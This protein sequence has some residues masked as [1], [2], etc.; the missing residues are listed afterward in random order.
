VEQNSEL[1]ATTRFLRGGVSLIV[2]ATLVFILLVWLP[3]YRRFF[4][5]SLGIGI[6]VAAVLYF[7]NKHRPVKEED[8]EN[9]RP[10]GPQ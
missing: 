9:K 10:L 8:I 1:E 4:L 3:A 2:V 6:M 7:W 5:G